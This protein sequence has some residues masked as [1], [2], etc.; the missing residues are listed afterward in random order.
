[1]K[2]YL[3]SLLSALLCALSLS[4]R[5]IA[6]VPRLNT[7]DIRPDGVPDEAFWQKVPEIRNFMRYGKP[8]MKNTA[9][10]SVKICLDQQNL[11]LALLCDEPVKV[12]TGTPGTGSAWSADNVEIFLGSLAGHDWSRQIVFGLN[13]QTYN[14][15]IS[16]NDFQK[17][18]KI[19]D[20]SWSAEIII[21]LNKLGNMP[22]GQ[23]LF[24][25]FR[26]RKAAR[27]MQSLAD[28]TWALEMDKF[29]TL[30]IYTPAENVVYG[31][32]S[33][34]ITADS[35]MVVWQ[36]AGEC[37]AALEY[38]EKGSDKF[39]TVYA[40]IQGY[41]PDRAQKL[42]SVKLR[43]LKP[44][45]VY[46][47]RINGE[48]GG[49]FQTL[50]P[51]E[52]DFSFAACADT[53][54]RSQELAGFLQQKH[55]RNADLLIHLG[56]TVSGVTGIGSYYDGFLAPL[57]KFWDKPFYVARGNHEARGNAPGLFFDT[58]Y[59]DGRKAYHGFLHKGVYFLFLDASEE[60]NADP[61]F[62]EEQRKWLHETIQSND[63]KNARFRVLI[64]H[65]ALHLVKGKTLHRLFDSLPPEV[66]NSFDLA[67]A[68][69]HHCDIK[70][71]PGANKV[72]STHPKYTGIAPEKVLPFLRMINFGGTFSVEK[73]SNS[74]TVTRFDASG[75]PIDSFTIRK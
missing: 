2:T 27:E 22:N 3:P 61:Q 48:T 37:R 19:N 72:V 17:T 49:S 62:W 39:Q 58:I 60:Y 12:V 23:L 41:V 38:R 64:S 70:I 74:L 36:S 44:G 21:P 6:A 67:L 65:Y 42:H 24:N 16:G 31:P 55:I 28:L 9:D 25:M 13:G 29:V 20:K 11:Y 18:V 63:F 54:A 14:E 7:A 46:E 68:G 57:C 40:D 71:L 8:G 34:Q 66:Q 69:H 52:A 75:K 35:A 32:W 47:Y 26:Y 5:Q 73:H 33:T 10:T 30:Q 51:A 53:H 50:D 59:P 43:P 15:S 1:M 4:A 56:D 45:T